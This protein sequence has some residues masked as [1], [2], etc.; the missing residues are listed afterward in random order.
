MQTLRGATKTNMPDCCK[1]LCQ[2]TKVGLAWGQREGNREQMTVWHPSR[3]GTAH[4]VTRVGLPK[5][6]V[7]TGGPFPSTQ[8]GG[9]LAPSRR[10]SPKDGDTEALLLWQLPLVPASA[11][12]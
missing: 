6:V 7:I 3:E 5:P 4:G 11:S 1:V 12:E 9:T 10:G 8:P 2:E